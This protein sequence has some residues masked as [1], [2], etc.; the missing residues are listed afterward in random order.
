MAWIGILI[1]MGVVVNNGIVLID[2]V[3][4]LRA[5]GMP[6]NEAIL[7]GGKD[8]LRPILMTAGTTIL[9][10]T[11]LCFGTTLIGG[12]GPPYFPMARAIVGGLAFSTVVT[13]IVLPSIYIMLDDL[14][15]WSLR[16]LAKS[17][18]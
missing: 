7:Q 15:S 13:L 9:G 16:I 14:R 4:Q 11:P 2:H 1:L 17:K 12:G 10:L 5:E 18:I 6:R 3:N 8:R